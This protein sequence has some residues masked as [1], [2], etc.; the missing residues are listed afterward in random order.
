[1]AAILNSPFWIVHHKF[2]FAVGDFRNL[3]IQQIIHKISVCSDVN[4]AT[5]AIAAPPP[6]MHGADIMKPTE[7][8]SILRG[9]HLEFFFHI[10]VQR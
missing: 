1:M 8:K 3:R 7:Q 6:T 2:E 10:A 9:G 5:M 4:G